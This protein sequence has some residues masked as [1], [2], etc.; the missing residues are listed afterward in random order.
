M[1]LH[2]WQQEEGR[3]LI[4]SIQQDGTRYRVDRT[5]IQ[6]LDLFTYGQGVMFWT[7][8]DDA[9]VTKVWYSKAELSEN[10]WFQ[11]DQKIVDLKIYSKLRQ[12]GK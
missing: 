10:R 7:T 11:V 5:G 2:G 1:C 12:Q 9:D 3:G 6:G 4:E 8:I